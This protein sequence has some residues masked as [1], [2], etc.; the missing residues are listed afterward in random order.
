VTADVSEHNSNL[1]IGQLL[2]EPVQLVTLSAHHVSVSTG[3]RF[4]ASWA[5]RVA[6]RHLDDV[7]Q[8]SAVDRDLPHLAKFLTTEPAELRVRE[9]CTEA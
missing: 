5:G 9:R 4:R 7:G 8:M 2:D 1:L 3:R 6:L